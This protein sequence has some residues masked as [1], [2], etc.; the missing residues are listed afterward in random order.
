MQASTHIINILY[1][2]RIETRQLLL[3]RLTILDLFR[4]DLT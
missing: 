4:L 2:E 1:Y 3:A